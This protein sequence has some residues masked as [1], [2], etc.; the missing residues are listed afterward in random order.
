ML[1]LDTQENAE[2]AIAL[3]TT[4]YTEE[5]AKSL[6]DGW[7]STYD[8]TLTN[9]GWT[10]PRLIAEKL[11]SMGYGEETK[12][13]VIDL[14]CGT[15]LTGEALRDAKIG[16]K[17]I[18]GVDLSMKSIELLG[19]EKTG[20]YS[21]TH[22]ASLDQQMTFAN[23]NEF[24]VAICGGV[25]SYIENFPTFFAEVVRIVRPGGLFVFS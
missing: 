7:S 3:K 18:V 1:V 20:L 17:G 8:A 24:D 23:D 4:P 19:T 5:G 14:G 12:D 21:E 22:T 16:A 15:G 9:W 6:Y 11:T 25:M 2:R 10:P 13:N